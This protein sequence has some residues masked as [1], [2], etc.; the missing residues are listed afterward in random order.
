MYSFLSSDGDIR[1]IGEG[2]NSDVYLLNREYAGTPN[3]I[4]RVSHCLGRDRVDKA[5]NNYQILKQNGIK[6]VGFLEECSFDGRAAVITENLHKES[7]TYLDANAHLLSDDDKQLRA[8][9]ERMGFVQIE[10]IEP[11][12]ERWFADNKFTDITDL[13]SFI[14]KHLD[15]LF[16]VSQNKVFLSYD[17]YFFRVNRCPV[18]NLDYII[19]DFD[20]IQITT[21]DNLYDVNKEEFKTALFQFM[22][23]F[24]VEDK[25]VQ[26][27]GVIDLLIA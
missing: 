24:V 10:S 17:C 12:E 4:I 20:D 2:G 5:L 9:N 1:L 21:V 19:A 18:T 27:K 23:W 13:D 6:T 15:F 22:N 3:A 16:A 8:I 14:K 7:Y 25:S 26:Y 11:K